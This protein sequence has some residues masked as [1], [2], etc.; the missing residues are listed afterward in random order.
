VL[1]PSSRL[2]LE[3]SD[4]RWIRFSAPRPEANIFHHP[5]WISL[6]AEC[7]GYRP[8][9]FVVCDPE[10]EICAGLPMME[11]HGLLAGRRWVSLPFS[12]HCAPLYRDAESLKA[13]TN[14]LVR[15]YQ[16]KEI[17]KIEVRWELLNNPAIHSYSQYVLQT[18]SLS[19]DVE[20][21]AKRLNRTHRQNISTAEE[22]GVRVER[23]DR[24]EHLHAFY[25]LQLETRRRHGVPVQPW[26]FFELLSKTLIEQGL[27]FVLLAQ[28]DNQHLAAGVFLHWGRTLTCKY[29]ASREDT[30]ALR[31][32]NLIFWAGIR[33]GCE[34]GYTLFDMGRTDAENTGLRRYKKGWGAEEAPLVYSTLS[35]KPPHPTNG[36][37]VRVM[38][39]VIRNSPTWVCKMAGELLYK[40][41]A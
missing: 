7:Y 5:A 11:V 4:E 6:L 25:R 15:A 39:A 1:E 36:M 38:N 35:A 14:G 31:P 23:G 33:W 22:R 29:A 27:G 37:S 24:P 41:F 30:L 12:D 34:N 26:R 21:V 32:N 10:G 9:I 3:P 19:P 16:E 17:P 2:F 18:V 20:V 40:H 8:F 13:L 28:K